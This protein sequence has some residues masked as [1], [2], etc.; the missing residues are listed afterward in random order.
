MTNSLTT[1]LREFAA[2]FH[3]KPGREIGGEVAES[4]G[5]AKELPV[6]GVNTLVSGVNLMP[7]ENF[8]KLLCQERKRS[9]RSRKP[10]LLML[11][12]AKTGAEANVSG[13]QRVAARLGE[14]IR[15]T[16]T[17]GWFETG[18]S[19]GV[20]FSELGGA[21]LD[22]AVESIGA[23]ARAA[24]QKVEKSGFDIS[25]YAFPEGLGKNS[26][27]DPVIY[28][29]VFDLNNKKK[30]S[31][32][33]KRAMDVSGSAFALIIL[34]PVLAV[35]AM[36]IKLTSKGPVF[37]RQERLGHF[38][39]P[40]VFLKFRS[41]YEST[42]EEIHKEYVQN[43]IA[44]RAEPRSDG[45][46]RVV[47][48]ITNDPRVTWIGKFMRRTSLDELPQFWNVFKGEMSLVG[49]RPPIRYEIEAYDVWH[50]RRFLEAKPGITG[51]W[52]VHGRSKTTFDE[53]VRLDLQY[54][55]T[56]SPLSDLKILL[57]TPRAVFSGDG[58]Y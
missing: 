30:V 31:Q 18:S 53:M 5:K 58:A 15:E 46:R 54:A 19:A 22:T 47:Y 40:F 37:F 4:A 57:Q 8:R 27:P 55:K 17:L 43:F 23:K 16:D 11:V 26:V 29:D 9:E 36:L 1:G 24:V 35:L 38:Q 45:G 34:S 52:Q 7:A 28:P 32:L 42:G 2:N 44:G 20:I 12:R 39:A 33:I 10:F 13:L 3:A 48:K 41:M 14:V 49:P 56:C 21:S 25:F 50:R 51:L 6:S